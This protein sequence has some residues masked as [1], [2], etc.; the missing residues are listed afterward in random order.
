MVQGREEGGVPTVGGRPVNDCVSIAGDVEIDHA[1]NSVRSYR[2]NEMARAQQAA[3]F[4]VEKHDPYAMFEF[5]VLEG[6]GESDQ[7]RNSGC[8]V[9]HGLAERSV[10]EPGRISMSAHNQLSVARA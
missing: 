2:R 1:G 3:L 9:D 10:G 5:M 4:E 6:G 7:D 8:V